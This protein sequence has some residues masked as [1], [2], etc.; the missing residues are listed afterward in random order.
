MQAA[1]IGL[2]MG[3]KLDN[4]VPDLDHVVRRQDRFTDGRTVNECAIGAVVVFDHITLLVPADR[5]MQSAGFGVAQLDTALR[6]AA[7][8]C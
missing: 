2:A 6:A 1:A 7:Y 8:F 5:G 3:M 4:G